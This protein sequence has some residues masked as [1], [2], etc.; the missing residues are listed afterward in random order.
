MKVTKQPE[1]NCALGSPLTDDDLSEAIDGTADPSIVRHLDECPYCRQRL[2]HARRIEEVIRR[3][4][5]P[6]AQQ[7]GDYHLGLLDGAASAS[8][9]AHVAECPHCRAELDSLVAFLQDE[10]LAQHTPHEA[11]Q[12]RKRFEIKMPGARRVSIETP[13]LSMIRQPGNTSQTMQVKGDGFAG[14][15]IW[16][17]QNKTLNGNLTPM[18]VW[19]SAVISC[20]QD[21]QTITVIADDVGQFECRGMVTGPVRIY[22]TSSHGLTV[23]LEGFDLLP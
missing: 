7:I 1:L 22:I 23:A 12:P 2:I 6:T 20:F 10:H 11:E 21:T 4:L 13:Q 9:A 19:Q 18:S 5:H 17:S 16:D 8:I 14:I 3:S 15:L